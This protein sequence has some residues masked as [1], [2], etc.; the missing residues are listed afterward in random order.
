[1]GVPGDN[2][3]SNGMKNRPN[4]RNSKRYNSAGSEYIEQRFGVAAVNAR[5]DPAQLAR[6]IERKVFTV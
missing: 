4:N 1:M 6:L 2:Q 3:C 5:T